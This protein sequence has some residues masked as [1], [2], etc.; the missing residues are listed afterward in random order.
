MFASLICTTIDGSA[1]IERLLTSLSL[2]TN[3]SFEIIVVIQ[4]NRTT[5]VA[6]PD[7]LKLQRCRI[8]T[9]QMIGLSAARNIGLSF[10]SGQICVFPDDD[11]TYPP[12]Y[13][14]DLVRAFSNSD[15]DILI[16]NFYDPNRSCYSFHPDSLSGPMK[17][18]DVS[19]FV[20]SICIAS[21]TTAAE[22]IEGFDERLGLGAATGCFAAEDFEFI[23]RA[24]ALDLSVELSREFTC[25][26][27]L[28][29]RPF[30]RALIR[31]F[32]AQGGTDVYLSCRYVGFFSALKV[33][34]RHVVGLLYGIVRA[35]KHST[36]VYLAR[37]VGIIR[38]LP[39]LLLTKRRGWTR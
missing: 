11:C 5:P 15:C 19:R 9:A 35:N 6:L 7:S 18:A 23:H 12:T 25:Y 1:T 21:R 22:K 32:G 38:Y 36:A 4:T 2:Q 24:L 16:G 28:E 37:V 27:S 29:P 31:R 13:V 10:A 30:S 20:S 26:H 14:E 39:M 17:H 3:D 34:F 8:I 33:G